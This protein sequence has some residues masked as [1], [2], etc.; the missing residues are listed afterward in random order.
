MKETLKKGDWEQAEASS[1]CPW[2]AYAKLKAS[3]Q[4]IHAH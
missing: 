1:F 3:N 4:Y 2:N